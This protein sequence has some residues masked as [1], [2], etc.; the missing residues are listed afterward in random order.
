[1]QKVSMVIPTYKREKVL[2][3]TIQCVL[4]QN[5]ENYEVII[6]DQ[7][8]EHTRET[9]QFLSR[10]PSFVRIIPHSPPSLTGA[11]NR[12]IIEA[13]AEIVIMIDDDVVLKNDFISEHYKYYYNS[14]IVAVTGRIEQK[15]KYV[16]KIPGF[17]KNELLQWIS[18]NIF[19]DENEKEAFR[20][21]GGNLSV[22]KTSA[23]QIGLFDENFI[24]T[25][26]GEE[27]D[28]SLRLKK[29]GKKMIYNPRSYIY[30]LCEQNGGVGNRARFDAFSVY[31]KA[32]NLAYL[33]EKND[34]KKTLYPYLFWYVYRPV[35]LKKDY[36]SPKGL[37]F[38]LEGQY[39]FLKGFFDGYKKGSAYTH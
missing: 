8:R 11:R 24:G 16:N 10:L 36:V 35:F 22:R 2:C 17:I 39:H 28:F 32:Y 12:G 5:F 27:I 1:M 15:K 21:A 4:N 29:L 37:M 3:D 33:I 23:L 30:H 25:A 31:S 19:C 9:Y 38:I 34:L 20:L 14:D 7:T 6:I 13:Y 18:P 26:W